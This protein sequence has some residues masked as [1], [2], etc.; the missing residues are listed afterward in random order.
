MCLDDSLLYRYEL[1]NNSIFSND[2]FIY[3]FFQLAKQVHFSDLEF[4]EIKKFLFA[5]KRAK[6]EEMESKIIQIKRAV[7]KHHFI[8]SMQH[9][10]VGFFNRS[11]IIQ[12]KIN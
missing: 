7:N 6:K 4:F 8:L 2:I 3:L 9:L 1:I 12:N 11:N 10:S 5:K